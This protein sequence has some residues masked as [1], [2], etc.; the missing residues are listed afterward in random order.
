[1][2]PAPIVW[3]TRRGLAESL[4]E[5]QARHPHYPGMTGLAR[6]AWRS[7][8]M[9]LLGL[10][11]SKAVPDGRYQPRICAEA[12]PTSNGTTVFEEEGAES[13]SWFVPEGYEPGDMM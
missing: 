11:K 9:R 1:M 2:N 6:K 7:E 4:E 8:G 12:C 5:Y 10:D 13:S 3:S